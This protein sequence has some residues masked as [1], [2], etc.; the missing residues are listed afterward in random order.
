[1]PLDQ[2]DFYQVM[3]SGEGLILPLDSMDQSRY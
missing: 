3:S 1:M 2:N